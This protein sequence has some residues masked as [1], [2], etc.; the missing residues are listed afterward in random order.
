M[1]KS[2]NLQQRVSVAQL[3]F[4]PTTLYKPDL[5][6]GMS[7]RQ[8][9]LYW[10]IQDEPDHVPTWDEPDIQKEV[11]RVWRS[12]EASKLAKERADKLKKEAEEKENSGRSLSALPS[13]KDKSFTL[14]H[15]LPFSFLV[16]RPSAYGGAPTLQVDKVYA[17]GK[18]DDFAQD[19]FTLEKISAPFMEK[20]F[21]LAPNQV[22]VAT[23]LPETEIYLVRAVAFTPFDDLWSDFI[24]DAENWTVYAHATPNEM[25]DPVAGM[26]LMIATEEGQVEQAWLQKVYAD[27]GVTWEKPADQGPARAPAAPPRPPRR[28]PVT[29]ETKDMVR[30]NLQGGL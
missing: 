29:K 22:D 30:N 5:S 9:Y 19:A 2:F 24:A 6:Y 21:S 28:H 10:K 17:T 14:L 3:A 1:G 25:T 20:V 13:A 7:F 16:E 18:V 8:R 27:A 26:K 15:P 11:E 23:N 12:R 4:G